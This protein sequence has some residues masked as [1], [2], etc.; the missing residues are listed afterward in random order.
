MICP[1]NNDRAIG[2]SGN[3]KQKWKME[4][5]NGN[6][7]NLMQMYARVKPLINDHLPMTTTVQRP[8]LYKD[9]LAIRFQRWLRYT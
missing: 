7:Q 4:T 6:S 9:H 8:P 1:N 5:E 2:N 3:G